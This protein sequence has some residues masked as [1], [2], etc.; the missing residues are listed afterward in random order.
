MK[1]L[2]Q[3]IPLGG[4]EG[5]VI[6]YSLQVGGAH[7]PLAESRS[8]KFSPNSRKWVKELDFL[9]DFKNYEE[10]REIL[11]DC[12]DDK[13]TQYIQSELNAAD[14]K[15]SLQERQIKA[16]KSIIRSVYGL[17]D[18]KIESPLHS[19]HPSHQ[20]MVTISY[21]EGIEDIEVLQEIERKLEV[22]NEWKQ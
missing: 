20:Q 6:Y 3:E 14:N 5:S 10:L 8:I 16:L 18:R 7:I 15:P 17:K 9:P 11:E 22:H 21:A 1:Y 19:L 12:E 13:Y 2:K 4:G